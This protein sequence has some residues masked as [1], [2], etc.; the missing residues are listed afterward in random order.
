MEASTWLGPAVRLR[1]SGKGG[2]KLLRS[3]VFCAPFLLLIADDRLP[4][5][6]DGVLPLAAFSGFLIRLDIPAKT[7][8][9]L[10]IH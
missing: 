4:D 8:E 7:I 9:L 3:A 6:P 2:L 1:S 10:P 5:G